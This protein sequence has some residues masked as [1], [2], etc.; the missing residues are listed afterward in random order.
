MAILSA[1]AWRVNNPCFTG[2][3]NELGGD[4]QHD[5]IL[6]YV[7]DRFR[8]TVLP[9]TSPAEAVG[10]M[11]FEKQAGKYTQIYERLMR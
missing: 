3:K 11:S 7:L 2:S 1:A 10:I 8:V 4:Y 9:S 6:N 5:M